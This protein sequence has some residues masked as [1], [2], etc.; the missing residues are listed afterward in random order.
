MMRSADAMVQLCEPA[1][2]RLSRA[3]RHFCLALA[4]RALG[5]EDAAEAER[6]QLQLEAGDTHACFY[7]MIYAQWGDKRSA[8]QWL[9]TAER[10]RDPMLQDLNVEP[11]YDP[12]RGEPEFK[13]LLQRLH[14][15]QVGAAPPPATGSLGAA[16]DR[17]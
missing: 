15:P 14:F 5:K 8:L 13:A 9:A 6:R 7:A 3:D 16:A 1:T 2:A 12:L 4:Y 17:A 11:L 10:L